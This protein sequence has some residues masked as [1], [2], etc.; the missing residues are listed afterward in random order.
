MPRPRETRQATRNPTVPKA[1]DSATAQQQRYERANLLKGPAIYRRGDVYDMLHRLGDFKHGY[2]WYQALDLGAGEGPVGRQVAKRAR[3]RGGI[4][5]L[6]ISDFTGKKLA[7]I[8][9]G[10][11]RETRVFDFRRIPLLENSRNRVF[12][13]FAIKNWPE[14]EQRQSLKEIFRVTKH[15]GVAVVMD[16]VSPPGLKGFQ[17]AE[18]QAKNHSA[19]DF[20]TINNV[21][22]EAE[23]IKMIEAAGF[24]VEAIERTTSHVNTTDWLASNQVVDVLKE[25]HSFIEK[26]R[27]R[28]PNAWKEYKIKK[29][30]NHYEI[31]YPVIGFRCRK[32]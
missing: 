17:N 2:G 11:M 30:G 21:P 24:N 10:P 14:A 3:R 31:T 12:V 15:G 29:V 32:P 4:T 23:W 9:K 20:K 22:T 18:R 25:Y 16:M 8:P 1:K 5:F 26:A 27:T 28:Y 13:R 19:G 7:K 6:T